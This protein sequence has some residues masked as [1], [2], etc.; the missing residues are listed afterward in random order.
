MAFELRSGLKTYVSLKAV[1]TVERANAISL[2]GLDIRQKFD[3]YTPAKGGHA[4]SRA[5]PTFTPLTN[6]GVPRAVGG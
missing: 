3:P 2:F 6:K 5:A 4:R 1:G